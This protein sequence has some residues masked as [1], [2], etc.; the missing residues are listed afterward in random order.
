MPSADLKK[1]AVQS[2]RARERNQIRAQPA[3]LGFTDRE[4]PIKSSAS[5]EGFPR[6]G[7]EPARRPNSQESVLG[8]AA[9]ARR[10]AVPTPK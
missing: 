5:D 7:Y 2:E 4:S 9:L 8:C 10:F 1:S 3:S 6:I